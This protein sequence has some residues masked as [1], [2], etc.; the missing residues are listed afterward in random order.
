[1]F[2]D[3]YNTLSKIIK[4]RVDFNPITIK[5]AQTYIKNKEV[6]IIGMLFEKR[7][8]KNENLLLVVDDP[9]SKVNLV[10]LKDKQE[11]FKKAKDLL[12]DNVIGFKCSVISSALFIVN[13]IIFPDIPFINNRNK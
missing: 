9:T 4:E 8:T 13:E 10:V 2:L 6:D 3:K 7:M 5:D 11:I 1:M 12:L